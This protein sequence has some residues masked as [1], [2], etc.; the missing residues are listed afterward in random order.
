M[1]RNEIDAKI[2]AYHIRP[3]HPDDEPDYQAL[4]Q[5]Y[6]HQVDWVLPRVLLNPFILSLWSLYETAIKEI[7]SL[8]QKKQNAPLSIS[9]IKGK[10]LVDRVEKYFNHVLHFPLGYTPQV[11]DCLNFT[12][13]LRNAI[14][15]HN[16]RISGLCASIQKI[17]EDGV[18]EG[19]EMGTDFFI[20]DMK[21]ASLVY[22]TIRDHL[23]ML[24][25]RYETL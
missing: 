16:S 18:Y 22:N 3:G 20:I 8:I 25:G 2:K 1:S 4:V 17:I 14:V 23:E 21:F 15:H 13:A 12:G 7:A 19:I 6:Y 11:K 9:D 24:M 10:H 5:D